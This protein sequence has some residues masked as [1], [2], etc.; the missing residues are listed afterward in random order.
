M[1]TISTHNGTQV[2]I[3]HNKRAKNVV[4]K[5]PHIDPNGV[6]E[7][8]HQRNIRLAYELV[9]GEARKEYNAKQKRED[10]QI[11]DYYD[12]IKD[13]K[14]QNAVYEMIVG[15][16]PNAEESFGEAE[17]KEILRDFSEN[18]FKRNPNLCLVGAYYHADEQGKAPHLHIDY[19]PVAE[20]YTRGM[21]KQAG[22]NKALEQMGFESKSKN[23]TAQMLWERR[24]N[25]ALEEICKRHGITVE[26]PQR[27]GEKVKHLEKQEYIAT[28]KLNEVKERLLRTEQEHMIASENLNDIEK[29]IEKKEMVLDEQTDLLQEVREQVSRY[30]EENAHLERQKCELD[31]ERQIADQ[32][33][34]EAL[35]G[36]E[37]ASKPVRRGLFA[38]KETV[39]VPRA[40]YEQMKKAVRELSKR[41]EEHNDVDYRQE[42]EIANY[43]KLQRQQ[44][45]LNRQKEQEIEEL[46]QKRANID[47]EISRQARGIA[48][49][50]IKRA[51]ELLRDRITGEQKRRVDFMQK[52]QFSNGKTAEDV[53]QEREAERRA[54]MME[55]DAWER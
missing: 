44:S 32:K 13:S 50:E 27:D 35:K 48:D 30:R 34:A 29:R 49:K 41:V 19:F 53:F 8:W 7:A 45:A 20:G 26:H 39:E 51:E 2:S 37:K 25:E 43:Q 11:A 33:T 38:K 18:W 55:R 15:V 31:A 22:L 10:R 46:R 40:E 1:A 24:E 12:K 5:E 42:R 54:R 47:K 6:H 17:C 4:S 23:V 9:F 28:Q 52:L 16:Y 3:A 36:L 21:K 14:G